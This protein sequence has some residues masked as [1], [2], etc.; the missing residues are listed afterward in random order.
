MIIFEILR[1]VL[2]LSFCLHLLFTDVRYL[3]PSKSSEVRYLAPSKSY[4]IFRG[5]GMATYIE[6]SIHFESR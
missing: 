5:W 2:H 3:A 6:I 4:G 1:Y